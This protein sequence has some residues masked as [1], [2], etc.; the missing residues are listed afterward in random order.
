MAFEVV[1]KWSELVPGK[2]H[3]V[4]IG[5]LEVGLFRVGDELFAMENRCPHADYPLDRGELDGYVVICPAHAWDFDVRTGFKPGD[6]D[7]FPIPCFAVRIEGDEV[8]VDV[9]DVV[10][11]RR[12]RRR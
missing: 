8:S 6:D 11:R 10:N 1:A 2:G 4:R 9:E 7:G 12:P 5:E 3:C